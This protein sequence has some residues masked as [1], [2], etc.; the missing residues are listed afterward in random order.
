MPPQKKAKVEAKAKTITLLLPY[1][2]TF[3]KFEMKVDQTLEDL[4]D[5]IRESDVRENKTI[6]ARKGISWVEW[7]YFT[8]L[9]GKPIPMKVT[10]AKLIQDDLIFELQP[11]LVEVPEH[12]PRP[13]T[14]PPW[15]SAPSTRKRS[16]GAVIEGFS[17]LR[18]I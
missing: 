15:R 6:L 2:R 14:T 11:L 12:R 3:G 9:G 17:A 7:L 10:L 16:F 8:E 1:Q 18:V 13:V 4:A 5:I